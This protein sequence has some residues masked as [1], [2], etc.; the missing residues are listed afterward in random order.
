MADGLREIEDSGTFSNFGPVNTRFEARLLAERFEGTGSVLTV[1]NATIGLMMAIRAAVGADPSGTRRYALMPSFTFA[2][3]AH[4]AIWCGL[5]PLFCDIDPDTWM[6]CLES[7]ERLLH[8]Y[9]DQIAV[10]VPCATFGANLDLRAYARLSAQWGIPVVVDAAAS[11]GALDPDGR[12]FAAGAPFPVVFSMHAT[13]T[14][15]VGEGGFVYADD[16]ALVATLREM[17]NFGF[18]QPRSA[19]MLGINGKLSEVMALLA[20]AKLDEFDAVLQ[21]RGQ[22]EALYRAQLPGWTFQAATGLR[23]AAPFVA[24]LPPAHVARTT[25]R[26]ALSRREIGSGAYFSPHL[27]EQPYFQST[28][29]AGALR[30]TAAVARRIVALP[31]AD[32]MTE[33]EVA[34]V[35]DVLHAVEAAAPTRGMRPAAA[36]AGA[37]N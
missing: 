1:N 34:E 5:T 29:V 35:C 17:A 10:M 27:A 8:L 22:L 15:A 2:A 21:R 18:G 11:L 28:A 32:T 26:E 23:H 3:T 24:V 37:V 25:A 19:T 33:A 12:P 13:K 6:P 4:A 31:I 20:L 16:P 7:L 36:L 30:H 9:R 14:F